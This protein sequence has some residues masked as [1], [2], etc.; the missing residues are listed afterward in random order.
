VLTYVTAE[1][2]SSSIG[3]LWL[4]RGDAEP[5][6]VAENARVSPSAVTAEGG[7][8]TVLDWSSTGGRLVEWKDEVLRDVADSV[9]DIGTLGTLDGGALTLLANYDG[10]VGDLMRLNADLTTDWLASGVP[11]RAAEANAF[12]AA[13]DGSTGELRLLNRADGSSEV[14]ATGVARGSFGFAQQFAGI[15][16][17]TERDAE[18]NTSE[19]RL[20][21]TESGREFMVN[22]GVTETREVSFPSPGLLYNV[23]VGDDAGVWFSKAL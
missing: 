20:R 5:M 1:S 21:L 10:M 8:L 4:V 17:L 6:V 15:I 11:L 9:I 12:L 7:L 19:L 2:P 14:L 13:F 18:T 3:T 22:S 16:M 23:T